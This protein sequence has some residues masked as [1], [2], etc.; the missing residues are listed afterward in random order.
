MNAGKGMAQAA[1]AANAFEFNMDADKEELTKD[2]RQ[3]W[4]DWGASTMQGFGTTIV[5]AAMDEQTMTEAVE[6]A[7]KLGLPGEVIHDPTYPVRDGGVTHLLPVNT[8]AYIF[9]P[10]PETAPSLLA[11]MSLRP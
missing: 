6:Q 4:A 1:H 8:C 7:V 5:V 11:R 9:V 3:A 10:V 2:M